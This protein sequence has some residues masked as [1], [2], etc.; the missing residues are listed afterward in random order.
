MTYKITAITILLFL[1]TQLPAQKLWTLFECVQ[2]ARD[3]NVTVRQ[4]KIQELIAG[5]DY[6]QSQMSRLPTANYS[7]NLGFS[8]GRSN[9]PTTGI[10]EN[11]TFFTFGLNFQTSVDIFNFYSKKNT[12]LASQWSYEAAKATTEKTRNDISLTVANGYLQVLLAR[13]QEKIS[14]VQLQQSKA[15]LYNIQKLVDAG[16]LPELNAAELEAQ[17][18]TDS[19]NLITARGNIEQAYLVLKSY[20][21]MEADQQIQIDTPSAA[22]IPLENIADLQPAAVYILALQNLPQ[23]KANDFRLLAAQ[24]NVLAARGAMY[25]SFSLFGNLGSNFVY[26]RTPIYQ[27]T[28]SGY[29]PSGLVVQNGTDFIPVQQPNF[30]QGAQTGYFK[31]GSFGRQLGD[32]FGQGIG[33]N[34]TVP[35]FNGYSI[36]SNWLRAKLNISTAQLQK[37]QDNQ[38]VKQD[39]YQAYNSAIVALEK[40]NAS[41][42]SVEAAQRSYDFSLKRFDIGVLGTYELTTNQNNLLRAKLQYVLNQFDYVF[43]MK[44][45]EFYKGQGLKL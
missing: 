1:S 36:R 12:I 28:I 4:N 15:Q 27:Q 35:L 2:Y 23:Q 22:Q 32:N 37:I 40:F 29:S 24:K 31:P 19:A 5:V 39:I 25:P 41:A 9:N 30:K 16:S 18:A 7:N 21:N 11:Q 17:V 14:K 38:T 20:M 44:V 26:F 13:E 6:K 42:K 3:S 34:I 8:S 43:K 45:L 10:L 33:I